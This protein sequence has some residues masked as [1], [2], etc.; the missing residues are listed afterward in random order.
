[1]LTRHGI[2][3]S[4]IILHILSAISHDTPRY[5]VMLHGMLVSVNLLVCRLL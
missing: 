3:E 4:I 1:M 2:I 5:A